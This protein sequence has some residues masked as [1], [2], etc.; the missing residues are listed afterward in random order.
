MSMGGK[1]GQALLGSP[2][3]LKSWVLPGTWHLAS[4]GPFYLQ[5]GHRV[6]WAVRSCSLS[7]LF[8]IL[9][10]LPGLGTLV[11]HLQVMAQGPAFIS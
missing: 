6:A 1:T 11:W 5:K 9:Q 4:S 7:W 3:C 2:V 10:Q 8:S